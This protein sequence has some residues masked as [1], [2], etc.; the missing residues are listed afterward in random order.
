MYTHKKFSFQNYINNSSKIIIQW[1][2]ATGGGE[3]SPVNFPLSFSN[4]NYKVTMTPNYN[5][6]ANGISYGWSI[7]TGQTKTQF[8]FC[9]LSSYAK[10]FWIAIGY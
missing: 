5:G 2:L 1:G 9:H 8:E 3:D 10:W 4:T 6:N 7:S